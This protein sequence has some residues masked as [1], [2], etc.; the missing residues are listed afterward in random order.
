MPIAL[1]KL[2]LPVERLTRDMRI[3]NWQNYGE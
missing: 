2:A 1:L 3:N